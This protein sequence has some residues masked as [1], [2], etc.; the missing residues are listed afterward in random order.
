MV[1]TLLFYVMIASMLL[2]LGILMFGISAF[3][4][5]GEFSLK[6]SNK[7]MQARVVAQFI[8]VLII[9]AFAYL[10]GQS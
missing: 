5:G 9:V 2:V 7:A 10:S 8:A 1:N 4:K 3:A 6:Y